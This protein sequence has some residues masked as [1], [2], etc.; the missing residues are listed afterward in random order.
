MIW[1]LNFNEAVFQMLMVL[2]YEHFSS[3]SFYQIAGKSYIQ[4]SVK[5]LF[6]KF[7]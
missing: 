1:K 7:L 6:A 4:F 2:F 5:L 3:F